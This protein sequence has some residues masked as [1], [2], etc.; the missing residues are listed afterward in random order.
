M[1][2]NRL[3][4]NRDVVGQERIYTCGPASVQNLLS[5]LGVHVDEMQL[6]AECGTHEGGTDHA[7]LIEPVLN[8]Y[9]PQARWEVVWMPDDPC[10]PEQK[11]N[12]WRHIVAS[13]DA[14]Y[15]V[16]SNFVAPPGNYPRGT[17]GTQSPNYGGGTV[18]HYTS[19]QGFATEDNGERHVLVVDSGFQ[20]PEYWI[21]FDQAATLIPPKAYIW[22]SAAPLPPAPPPDEA[23]MLGHA[24]GWSLSLERY[25][26]LLPAVKEALRE[27]DCT[28]PRRVAQWFAQLGHECGGGLYQ[29]EL[30]SGEAY[31]GRSDLGNTQPGDGPRYKG[32]GAIQCTGRE[33]YRQLSQWAFERN[34][35]PTPTYF[36]DNP[37]ELASDTFWLLGATWYWRYARPNINSMCDAEDIEGVT[38]AI[39]G[40]THGLEDRRQ[41]YW[42]ALEVAE[43]FVPRGDAPLVAPPPPP[44]PA[45]RFYP[46]TAE[47]V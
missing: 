37:E 2:E 18:F 16:L 42:K 23:A 34:F 26:Q 33:N 36:V 39:N 22:A 40:G 35:V 14:G 4:Y 46:M 20:P 32:R 25:R 27:A 21:S 12:L 3:N 30:A 9:A 5:A 13:V 11:E 47:R 8:K 15:G 28:N 7:G 43:A 6:A 45:Q 29:E 41:R 24:M 31:N 17:R 1:I 38:R 44:P 10:T 19:I